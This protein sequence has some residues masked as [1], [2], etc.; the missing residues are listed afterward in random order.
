MLRSVMHHAKT[1]HAADDVSVAHSITFLLI[2]VNVLYLRIEI[3]TMFGF[4]F[5]A[6]PKRKMGPSNII[7]NGLAH[8]AFFSVADAFPMESDKH[9]AMFRRYNR[10]FCE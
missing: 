3:V 7:I 8:W 10:T 6:L 1:P 2:H 4:V 5:K 9:Q